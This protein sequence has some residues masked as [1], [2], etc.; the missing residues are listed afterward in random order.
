[1]ARF[2]Q[3]L[4][5]RSPKG[6][7]G[8][9]ASRIARA[10]G[11]KGMIRADRLR[12]KMIEYPGV[13][14]CGFAHRLA[15][16]TVVRADVPVRVRGCLVAGASA[17]PPAGKHVH[18]GHGAGPDLLLLPG[19]DCGR[20]PG[21][22]PLLRLDADARRSALYRADLGRRHVVPR[23]AAGRVRRRSA[24]RPQ[25]L[26]DVRRNRGFRRSAGADRPGRRAYRQFHQRRTLGQ[27]QRRAVGVHSG[28]RRPASNA[29]VRGF[30]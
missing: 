3:S 9:K 16:D 30:S 20:A 7:V 24:V 26:Q 28:R 4:L 15:G 21:L 2:S 23:R 17:G 22:S 8:E 12:A 13:R 10:T 29:V 6:W 18:A 25:A 19:R 1:M 27:A 14:S 11:G 5:Q